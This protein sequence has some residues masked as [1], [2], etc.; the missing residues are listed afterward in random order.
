M[1]LTINLSLIIRQNKLEF[2]KARAL[3]YSAWPGPDETTAKNS[4]TFAE[5]SDPDY[6]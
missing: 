1:R 5:K 2:K 3:L 4:G 6:K